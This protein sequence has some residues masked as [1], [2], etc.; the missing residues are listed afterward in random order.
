MKET[1]RFDDPLLKKEDVAADLNVSTRQVDR[2]PIPKVYIG[3]R[4]PRWRQ[5]A[6]ADFKASLVAA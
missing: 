2:L 6:V 1:V 5:S 3:P 4:M